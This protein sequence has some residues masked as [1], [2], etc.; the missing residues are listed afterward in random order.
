MNEEILKQI[1]DEVKKISDY[2]T[3]K[4]DQEQ[5][6]KDLNGFDAATEAKACEKVGNNSI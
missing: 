3:N 5:I 2:V 1:L 4:A 6:K